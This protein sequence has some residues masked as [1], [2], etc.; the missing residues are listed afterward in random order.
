LMFLRVF[1]VKFLETTSKARRLKK[2]HSKPSRRDFWNSSRPRNASVPG[3]LDAAIHLSTWAH[4][5][6]KL[7]CVDSGI[8]ARFHPDAA[9]HAVRVEGIGFCL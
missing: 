4:M 5:R 6:Y 7:S 2:E 1:E 3:K 9:P 8:T